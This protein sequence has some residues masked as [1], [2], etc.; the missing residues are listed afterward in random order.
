MNLRSRKS[1]WISGAAALLAMLA[2]AVPAFAEPTG[3]T[4]EPTGVSG[5]IASAEAA[6]KKKS[7]GK[8]KS[9]SNLP[10]I[11]LTAEGAYRYHGHGYVLPRTKLVFRGRVKAELAD[12]TMKIKIFKRGK[13]IKSKTVEI[14]EA[15]SI[16]KFHLSFRT[17]SKGKYSAKVEL[18]DAQKVLVDDG[19]GTSVAVVRTGIR[20]GSRGVAVRLFQHELRQLAYVTPLNGRFDAATGRAFIAFRKVNGM[21]RVPVAGAAVAR[22]LVS[23]GGGFHL[24]YPGAGRHVEVSIRRQV[25][26][27]ASGGKVVRIYHVSTGAPATP[28]VRGTYRVYMKDPGTNAKGM[29]KSSYFIRGYAI[30]GYKDVPIYNA[31]HGCVR[32]PIPN[33]ASIFRWVHMGTRIDTYY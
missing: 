1:G 15:G 30:H 26:A 19:S 29:V 13:V 11:K 27:F 21:A 31:S 17:G 33:A 2:L 4:A 9:S 18:T 28:T 20:G 14:D 25:M 23:G 32:V 10:A 22:K 16:A 3:P 8:S 7:S 12:Q 24:R 6:A 5:P